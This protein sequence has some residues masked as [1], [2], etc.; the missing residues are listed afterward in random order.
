MSRKHHQLPLMV[1]VILAVHRSI[2]ITISA[3]RWNKPKIKAAKR[4]HIYVDNKQK[5]IQ[6]VPRSG[7]S[8]LN[9]NI[10][11][12]KATSNQKERTKSSKF[13][14]GIIQRD[15]K[16]LRG[17]KSTEKLGGKRSLIN[18]HYKKSPVRK[19]MMSTTNKQAQGN[20]GPRKKSQAHHSQLVSKI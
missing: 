8:K 13:T 11:S 6:Y 10:S 9:P 7:Q 18:Q 3:Q 15:S 4:E 16:G 20:P 17:F 19:P 5:S 14:A 12:R 2:D 1:Q